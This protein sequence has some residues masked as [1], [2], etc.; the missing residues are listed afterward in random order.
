[1]TTSNKINAHDLIPQKAPFV[2]VDELYDIGGYS[3]K[4]SF[5]VPQEHVFV[6]DQ[7][8]LKAGLIEVMA[9]S[10]AA[11]MTKFN[12]D[13]SPRVGFIGEVKNFKVHA[14][15]VSGNDLE[16]FIEIEKEVFN[17]L[18]VSGRITSGGKTLAEGSL[19]LVLQDQ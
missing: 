18:L 2:F 14:E 8:L 7:K 12:S 16:T 9:Q 19:K 11:G 6:A 17:V 13:D 3:W 1:M 10:V 4:T 15:A 5:T